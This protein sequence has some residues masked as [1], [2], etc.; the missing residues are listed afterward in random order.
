MLVTLLVLYLTT[1]WLTQFAACRISVQPLC[2]AKVLFGSPCTPVPLFGK[3][4]RHS[5]E[6]FRALFRRLS[7][8]TL[9]AEGLRRLEPG[10]LSQVRRVRPGVEMRMLRRSK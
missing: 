6:P 7:L 9:S 5:L 10:P 4:L 8:H 3:V 1:D 2:E